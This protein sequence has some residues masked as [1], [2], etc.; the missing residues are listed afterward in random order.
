MSFFYQDIFISIVETISLIIQLNRKSLF[1]NVL[2]LNSTTPTLSLCFH[3]RI[4]YYWRHG[5]YGHTISFCRKLLEAR[6]SDLFINMWLALALSIENDT[7]SAIEELQRMSCRGDLALLFNVCL[8]FI[9]KNAI[10]PNTEI[11]EEI[12]RRIREL[13]PE[14][15]NFCLHSA[16]YISWAFGKYDLAEK[17]LGLVKDKEITY[18]LYGW[19]SLSKKEYK[20]SYDYFDKVLSNHLK[21]TDLLSLYGKAILLANMSDFSNSIQ[22]F[23]KILSHYDFPEIHFEKARIY[24]AM[25]RWPLATETVRSELN[26]LVSP[27]ECHLVELFNALLTDSDII[28]AEQFMKLLLEDIDQYEMKNW[29]LALEIGKSII[30]LC[31]QTNELIELVIKIMENASQITS[32]VLP[33][34]SYCHYMKRDYLS[35]NDILDVMSGNLTNPNLNQS[36]NLNSSINSPDQNSNQNENKNS[37]ND[38]NFDEKETDKKEENENSNTNQRSTEQTFTPVP[39]DIYSLDVRLSTLFETNR[40][41]EIADKLDFYKDAVKEIIQFKTIDVRFYRLQTGCT[42]KNVF[43]LCELILNHIDIVKSKYIRPTPKGNIQFINQFCSK[44]F[45][46][47]TFK[48][49]FAPMETMYERFLS[50]FSEFRLDSIVTALDEIILQNKSLV[51]SPDGLFGE[52]VGE[53]FKT[54]FRFTGNAAPLKLQYAV[55]LNMNQKY[56][57]SMNVIQSY[58]IQRWPFRL[59]ISFLTAAMNEAALGNIESTRLYLD[60]VIN[61][62]PIFHTLLDFIL[63]KCKIE[64]NLMYLPDSC[65][66]LPILSLLKIL[67]LIIEI[68]DYDKSQPYFITAAALATYPKEKAH[69][70]LRQAKLLASKKQYQK[71]FDLLNKLS[72]HQKYLNE[73]VSTE[74]YIYLHFL[75][76]ADNYMLKYEQLCEYSPSAEHFL[77]AGDAFAAICEFEYAANFYQEA[78]QLE[79]DTSTLQKMV[80]SLIKSHQFNCA[81]SKYKMIGCTPLFLIQT[82]YKLKQLQKA[83]QYLEHSIQLIRTTQQLTIAPYIELRGDV[84][85]DLEENSEAIEDY[86]VALS[87]YTDIC[88]QAFPNVFIDDIKKRASIIA[89]KIG[90]LTPMREKVL[91]DY[92]LSLKF[93]NTNVEAF[94]SIFNFYKMRNDLAACHKLCIDFL[95]NFSSS[96]T[97]AL[98]LTTIETHD[99]TKSINSLENVLD[100]HPR[101]H[102]ALVRLIEIC[103]RAGKLQVAK[104]RLNKYIDDYSPGIYFCRGLLML[105][106]GNISESLK[107]FTIASKSRQWGFSAKLCM[108]NLLVNPERKYI[109]CEKEPL[110]SEENLQKASDL[111][112]TMQLDEIE[113]LLLTAELFSAHN[114]ESAVTRALELFNQVIDIQ[115]HNIPALVG[116]ARCSIRLGDKKQANIYID[117]VLLFKPFHETF[118]YFEECY[119]MRASIISG[120]KDFRASQ[121]FIFL[122]IDLNLSS[123]KGW[124]KSGV[125]YKQNK[126]FSEAAIAYS[127]CW[128][129]G[130]RKDP[131]I[132]YNYAYCSLKANRPDEALVICRKLLDD[133]PGKTDLL[134]S[135]MIPAFK[136]LK[137]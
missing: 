70:I 108:F 130:D 60:S 37:N 15:N 113:N 104:N 86:K 7:D 125:V 49:D 114:T 16:A 74:A 75:G 59:P 23:A 102:R 129:L 43:E 119:L 124:E 26:G 53:I 54:L 123:K 22:I 6:N 33:F 132:G 46:H 135:I 35:A 122:A 31:H 68:G 55:Y 58:L 9:H 71:A 120:E 47:E 69:L 36:T 38:K 136:K 64:R 133:N 118:A 98:L 115:Q 80:S 61:I 103:A 34:L 13:A 109:W 73:A 88:D 8:F 21:S 48:N 100:A 41:A 20:N 17:F 63:L 56:L 28:Q 81:I 24:I 27:L 107:H 19:I 52:K 105:Y 83:K 90:D 3:E 91:D 12:R 131:E 65:E 94:V 2:F 4:L 67:D 127:R 29:K 79:N 92:Y 30:S 14:S 10:E 62:S 85:S 25:N 5:L 106:F 112:G 137:S 87:I 117:K 39:D 89:K 116:I 57:E 11:I 82:L 51:Y 126:M 42:G 128:D 77:M 76:D 66:N 96:E 1:L 45:I 78:Y 40:I 72:H 99:F 18:S 110:T 121:H 84:H 50:F 93:D 44:E 95:A 97:V 101:F 134:E 111:L 32:K